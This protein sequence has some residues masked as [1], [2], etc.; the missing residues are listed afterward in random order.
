MQWGDKT[1]AHE[2]PRW[3][4]LGL[5]VVIGLLLGWVQHGVWAARL[6]MQR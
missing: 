1:D 5:G 3:A 4:C 6:M 2:Y